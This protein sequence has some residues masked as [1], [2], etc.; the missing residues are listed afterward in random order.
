M[1]I[2]ANKTPGN[3]GSLILSIFE[4]SS[5]F[6]C[7]NVYQHSSTCM[8]KGGSVYI[9]TNVLKSVLYTGVR[10]NLSD[11]IQQH[12]N[13]YHSGSFTARYNVIYLVYYRNFSSIIEAIAE[14]KRIKGGSRKQKCMLI[15]NIN[16]EWKDLFEEDVSKW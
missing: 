11:R 7:S 13:K 9:L 14:E 8:Q 2:A 4:G 15:D 16:L 1:S 5:K 12:R 3:T 10:S 6:V